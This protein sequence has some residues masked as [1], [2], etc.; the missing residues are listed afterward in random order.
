MSTFQK[1]R[2]LFLVFCFVA[3]VKV[4][5]QENRQPATWSVIASYTIPGKA[6]G[7]AWDGT[8]IYFGIYGVNGNLI[9]KFD[10]GNGTNSIQCT[11]SFDDAYGL[12]YKSPNLVTID[13]PASSATP[14][15]ALEFS[16]AGATISTITLPDHY[17]SGIAYDAGNYWVCTYYPDPG[18]VYEINSSGAILSQFIP[19]NNQ[20]WDICLQGSDLWIADYYG[21][22]LYKVT[23]SGTLLESHACQTQK[24]AGIVYDGTY[25]WYC[26]GPLGGNSTLYKVDLQ[27]SGTPVI[28][29]PVTSHDYG[30][31][32]IGSSSTWNCQVQNTG[33][34]DLI[35]TSIGI[36]S[37]EPV[38]TTF[39]TPY[40]LTPGN[41]VDIPLTYTPVA[42]IPLNAQVSINSSDPVT[43]VVNV[44]L[45]G[46][47]VFNGPHIYLQYTSHD[48]GVRRAGAYSRWDMP[49]TN[50][51]N[52]TLT[53]TEL[54]F[55]DPRFTVDQ[56]VTLPLTIPS[57]ATVLI[58]IWFHPEEGTGYYGTLTIVSDATGQ[59]SLE[60]TLEGAGVE[61]DYPIGSQLWS[62]MI[63][64]GYDNSVKAIVPIQDITGDGVDD[65]VVGSEDYNIR[66]FNGNA[67]GQGDVL[68]TKEI[69]SGSVYQQNNLTTIADIDN[70][71]YRDVI[72]GTTG[73][74]RSVVALS[75]RTGMQI[76][77]HDTH[78]YGGGG[79]IY[80]VDSRYDYNSDGVTD[81]LAC[82]GND[83]NNTGPVRVYC[84]NGLSGTS[85][86]ERPNPT[87]GPVFS[88]IGT[89][90]FTGDGKPDVVAGASNQ[91]ENAGRLFGING[92]NGA[93]VWTNF[94]T[95]T[96]V[97][98][99]MQLNDI[100][101]DGRKDIAAGDFGGMVL[102]VN[103][104]SGVNVHYRDIGPYII[105]RLQNMGDMNQD[106]YRDILV[107]HSGTQ[108]LLIDGFTCD[109]IWTTSLADKSWNVGNIGDVTWD[110][111]NDAIIGT[112]FQDNYAY[113]L[114]GADGSALKVV[115]VSSAVDAINAIPDIVGDSS[116]EMILGGRNG[117]VSCL[118]GGYDTTTTPVAIPQAED[119]QLNDVLNVFPN[120]MEEQ[121]TVQFI[122]QEDSKVRIELFDLSGRRL[123]LIEDSRYLRGIHSV[124]WDG[125][126]YGGKQITSGIY[127]LQADIGETTMS[128][129][130]VVR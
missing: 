118:S 25:L 89:E 57:T 59:G 78:E 34:A 12:T 50:D 54:S 87:G 67:S 10:P 32:A 81:V 110:G 113:F 74:D 66:C 56:W 48:W 38:S 20:P 18:V 47:G 41:S 98:G 49:V 13:Q 77:K 40:T 96:S 27:G 68:W 28:N 45:T 23:T 86:W 97:W 125:Q 2:I 52:A 130:I 127:F 90:D 80:Q 71:G 44:T 37:G 100:T 85:I 46:Q 62:Y 31:V 108:G 1:I 22:M 58:G 95:G 24:P 104:V 7:L 9:Y 92:S 30:T 63:S 88:V 105:L 51:G 112:L 93:I 76:W 121:L 4:T 43:P 69:Y 53:I 79:W 65:V 5:G 75:G 126:L 106:G 99:L 6:S 36:P 129:K 128:V 35:I 42:A 114:D 64:S 103:A 14:S 61:S 33:N 83:G 124:H 8:Y 84:L 120:P 107:A 109:Y 119:L 122:L 60:V 116:M 123:S 11:G 72:V 115:P 26:D 111:I 101:G 73:G 19:P 21:N 91:Q 29:V 3:V 82:T 70:D 17:M 55:N 15:S 16:M 39:V 117:L 102:L 94:P